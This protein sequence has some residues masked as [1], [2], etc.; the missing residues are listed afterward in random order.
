MRG[1][2]RRKLELRT[3]TKDRGHGGE[4]L[5]QYVGA[6]AATEAMG[7][8][9]HKLGQL[10]PKGEAMGRGEYKL[11]EL[12]PQAKSETRI[13]EG[14]KLEQF[15]AAGVKENRECNQAHE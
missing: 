2:S 5:E 10:N 14:D 3:T 11:Y 7:C 13:Q 12:N 9:K 1:S 15:I 4:E 6:E 8:G